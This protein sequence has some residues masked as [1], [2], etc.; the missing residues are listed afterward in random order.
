MDRRKRWKV[1]PKALIRASL[2][3][4]RVRH[5]LRRAPS[6]EEVTTALAGQPDIIEGLEHLAAD[7]EATLR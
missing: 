6:W 4:S 3:W 7:L 2:G 5:G 1:P